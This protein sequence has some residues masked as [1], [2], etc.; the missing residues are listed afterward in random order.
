MCIIIDA[1]VLG[2]F[3]ADPPDDDAVPVHDW[4]TRRRGKLVYSTGGKFARE[5]DGKAR[6]R[7]A[8]YVRAGLAVEE[9]RRER[10]DEEEQG[11]ATAIR[12]DDPHVLALARVS[13][14]RLLY[15]DD[16]DLMTDFKT[17]RFIDR[18]RGKVYSSVANRNLLSRTRCVL[19]PP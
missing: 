8:D 10:L 14:A 4:L 16:G 7:L 18:P 11:L 19:N 2:K 3:L 15:T 12:S 1:N 9:V 6:Q 17:K 13:G 5:I